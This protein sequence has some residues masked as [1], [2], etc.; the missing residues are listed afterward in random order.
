MNKKVIV[1]SER[2]TD[3]DHW[4]SF[5]AFIFDMNFDASLEF[6]KE[7]NYI[8]ILVDRIDY[9]NEDTK[10]KMEMIRKISNDYIISR[11]G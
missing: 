5:I 7:K 10:G 3:M 4:V 1:S 2:I 8:D 11:I 6:I 9:T